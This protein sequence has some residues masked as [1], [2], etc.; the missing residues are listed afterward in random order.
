MSESKLI[1][2]TIIKALGGFYYVKSPALI[3]ECRARG[4]FRK[5][6]ITPYV[7]D[8]VEIE[9]TE[10]GKGYVVNIL[11]RKNSLVR[12]PVANIDNLLIVASV[13]DPRPN[14]LIIDKLIAVAVYKNIEPV[15]AITK[16]DL[17]SAEEL[18][19]TYKKAGIKTFCIN[20]LTGE[21][22]E[23]LVPL[24]AGKI[25]AFTGNSGAGKSSLI[26]AL[27][28]KAPRL[29][30]GETSKKLGRG[31]HTTRHVE[32]FELCGGYLADTPGFS[33][34]DVD[35][36]ET[37]LKEELADCFPEFREHVEHCKFRD[38][39]HQGETGCAVRKAV[40]DGKIAPSRYESYKIMYEDAKK[41]N[42]WERK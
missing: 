35:S 15:I 19:A 10:P 27:A 26:N 40:E 13:E 5:E 41:I 16:T 36:F 9:Q 18:E 29:K 37:I 6:G 28:P 2:G 1:S 17:A 33:S 8:N 24:F 7:G 23:A 34:V 14:P 30:T 11:P 22:V 38:C 42:T 21:G 20:S 25:T 12:P 4:V 39:A 3:Y 31:R 32:L